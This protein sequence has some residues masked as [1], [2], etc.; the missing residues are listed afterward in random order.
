MLK[1]GWLT[2][3]ALSLHRVAGTIFRAQVV[4]HD[5][6]YLS[7]LHQ[8]RKE[9][10]KKVL[11][12]SFFLSEGGDLCVSLLRVCCAHHLQVAENQ[13]MAVDVLGAAFVYARN[14]DL[15]TAFYFP[16][17]I[18]FPFFPLLPPSTA[19]FPHVPGC[20]HIT[21][22]NPGTLLCSPD[23]GVSSEGSLLKGLSACQASP[24]T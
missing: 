19:A 2:S 12:F 22:E 17:S 5:L 11:L 10:K 4:T 16:P 3:T 14:L 6:N 21:S 23:T 18:L 24:F 1:P 9:T 20:V 15:L 7:L 8:G 13:S